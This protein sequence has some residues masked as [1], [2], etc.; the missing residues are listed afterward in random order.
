[1]DE[2]LVRNIILPKIGYHN[3]L[4]AFKEVPSH[5]G[6]FRAAIVYLVFSVCL[7]SCLSV[8]LCIRDGYRIRTSLITPPPGVSKEDSIVVKE[9]SEL[10]RNHMNEKCKGTIPD[11]LDL[12][13]EVLLME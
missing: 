7:C 13:V 2:K 10:V 8:P 1:I 5:V 9:I 12:Y 3:E 11:E 4:L 6:L